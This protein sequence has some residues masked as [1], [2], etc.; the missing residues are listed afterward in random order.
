MET[1]IWLVAA[2]TKYI[3]GQSFGKSLCLG[4]VGMSI[5]SG[6]IFWQSNMGMG[7]S[8]QLNQI[9]YLKIIYVSGG[10]LIAM[11]DY[12]EESGNL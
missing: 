7:N 1:A 2:L 8:P 12:P 5:H 9:V 3:N 6:H 10:L 11:F 4:D